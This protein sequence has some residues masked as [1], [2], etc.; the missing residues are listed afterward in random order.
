MLRKIKSNWYDFFNGYFIGPCKAV[1]HHPICTAISLLISCI[2]SWALCKWFMHN[3][4]KSIGTDEE[5]EKLSDEEENWS[6][7]LNID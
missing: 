6:K 2:G 5:F 1:I 4:V 7:I 3:D